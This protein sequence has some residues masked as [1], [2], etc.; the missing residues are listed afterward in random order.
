MGVT[1]ETINCFD[2]V[3]MHL[4]LFNAHYVYFYA[5]L[6]I[7]IAALLVIATNLLL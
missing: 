5:N 1:V 2:Y 7:H 6:Q 4:S 3:F